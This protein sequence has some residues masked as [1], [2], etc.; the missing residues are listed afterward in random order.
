MDNSSGTL[1]SPKR[2]QSTSR[3]GISM[4]LWK[5]KLRHDVLLLLGIKSTFS[6][7]LEDE[8]NQP[9]EQNQ[10]EPSRTGSVGGQDRP[11]APRVGKEE[12]EH[13]QHVLLFSSPA[14]GMK[15][16]GNP[17][18]NPALHTQS[19]DAP[20]PCPAPSCPAQPRGAKGIWRLLQAP[21]S[22][23]N[24]NIFCLPVPGCNGDS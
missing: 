3:K 13:Q 11:G 1:L 23:L 22:H 24:I 12:R 5:G 2:L 17:C 16:K 6:L 14:P 8:Q 15:P 19:L 18:P 10:P 20:N 4:I 21:G 9:H 7:E